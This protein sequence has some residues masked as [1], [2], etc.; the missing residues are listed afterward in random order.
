MI[1]KSMKDKTVI[2]RVDRSEYDN[3]ESLRKKF[4]FRSIGEYCRFVSLNTLDINILVGTN[5][6]TLSGG[7]K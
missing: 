7:N 4:K 1:N 3:L 5:I 2:F 6:Y